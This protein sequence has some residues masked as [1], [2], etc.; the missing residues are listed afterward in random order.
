MMRVDPVKA[1][2]ALCNLPIHGGLTRTILQERIPPMIEEADEVDEVLTEI[3]VIL[4]SKRSVPTPLAAD[5]LKELMDLQYTV[6]SLCVAIGWDHEEAYRRVCESNLS[7]VRDG[8]EKNEAGKI[9]KGPNYKKPDLTSCVH[10][11]KFELMST[12][13]V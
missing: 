6:Q 2:H 4:R 10:G 12:E 13:E 1:F 7:K 9:L 5:A 3:D 11:A 8:F